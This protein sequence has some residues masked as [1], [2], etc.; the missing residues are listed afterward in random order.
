MISKLVQTSIRYRW[1][2]ILMTSLVALAGWGAFTNLP[3]DAVPDITN[4][5]V[6]VNTPVEALSPEEIERTVTVPVETS[7]NGIPGV[8]QVRSITRFGI[9]QVTVTFEED[10]DI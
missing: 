3:I 6:Q 9:S 4:V 10:T 5:Q 1:V 2:V 7:L 8:I